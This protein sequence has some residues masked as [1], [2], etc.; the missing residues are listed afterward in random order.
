MKT[1][2]DRRQIR[3]ATRTKERHVDTFYPP[4]IDSQPSLLSEETEYLATECRTS[5]IDTHLV[6]LKRL[7]EKALKYTNQLDEIRAATKKRERELAEVMERLQEEEKHLHHKLEHIDN[8]NHRVTMKKTQ[9]RQDQA[10]I[11][12]EERKM[13]ERLQM[14]K[15]KEIFVNCQ[16]VKLQSQEAAIKHRKKELQKER[17]RIEK[18]AYLVF[19]T[20]LS[21][22]SY[23]EFNNRIA[24]MQQRLEK[25][26]RKLK[27]LEHYCQHKSLPPGMKLEPSKLFVL[28]I[29]WTAFT[30]FDSE[31]DFQSHLRIK[32]LTLHW[33]HLRKLSGGQ[34]A[35][36]TQKIVEAQFKSTKGC[37]PARGAAHGIC[38]LEVN[39]E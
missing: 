4:S 21:T 28:V 27:L 30:T 13:S 38:H 39:N 19:K 10:N 6:T 22:T 17:L 1:K 37:P 2:P 33:K 15:E 16:M 12:Q 29:R 32:T 5:K 36:K 23:K 14:L 3:E 24:K 11:Q 26:Y 25:R 35:M 7:R 18:L 8:L 9:L 34:G 20:D 31:H